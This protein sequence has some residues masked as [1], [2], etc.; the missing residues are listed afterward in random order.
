MQNLLPYNSFK[1]EAFSDDLIKII[2]IEQLLKLIK[3]KELEKSK[4]LI[5][6]GGSNILFTKDFK[7][8]VLKNEI[9][10]VS[11]IKEDEKNI[12]LKVASGENWSDF[13]DYC[14][15]NGWGGLENLSL[16]PGT[17]GAAPVQNIGAYGVEIKDRIETVE[18]IE[19][20]T[21]KQKLFSKEECDFGYRDSI[22]K[23]KAKN[24]YFITFITLKLDKEP[25]LNTT[26]GDIK[27][28]LE[29][30]N[31]KN[32]TI[33]DVSNAVK[34]IR[35]DKL[36]NPEFIGNAGSFFKNPII[37]KKHFEVLINKYPDIKY[38]KDKN[39]NYK[40]AAGWLIENEGFKGF[41]QGNAAVHHK[42]ALV[43]INNGNAK[44]I[45]IKN[46]A[47]KIIET[48]NTKYGINLTPEVNIL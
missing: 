5:L 14:V 12:W 15:E 13:V 44:G 48:I 30:Q 42:Q 1:I 11:K 33:S 39:D 18:A 43:L 29:Q 7:G 36:P 17:A 23:N 40:I 4:Y 31:I 34:K 24:N 32:P 19:I 47:F 28:F 2:N 21:G 20:K 38:Y 22:F 25:V 46:L 37:D 26:Y 9:K 6:G 45:E 35:K 10:G 8:I 27:M 41:C 16:I 3:N